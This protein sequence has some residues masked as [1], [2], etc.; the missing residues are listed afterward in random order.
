M[1]FIETEKTQALWMDAFKNRDD[2]LMYTAMKLT[3]MNVNYFPTVADINRSIQELLEERKA[4]A[5]PKALDAPQKERNPRPVQ[6]ILEKMKSGQWLEDTVNRMD[7]SDAIAFA[8]SIWP[9]ISDETVRRNYTQI[10][11]VMRQE[12]MCAACMWEPKNCEIN[13]YITCLRLEPNGWMHEYKG[14]CNKRRG[15]NGL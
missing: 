5:K 2:N 6:F 11:E 10:K 13:G 12:E 14:P 9:E 4:E 3:L 8:R 1:A 7:V 15:D